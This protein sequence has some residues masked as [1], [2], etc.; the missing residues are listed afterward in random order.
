MSGRSGSC[1]VGRR[2]G[3]DAIEFIS[4]NVPESAAKYPG[5]REILPLQNWRNTQG[6]GSSHMRTILVHM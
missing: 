5:M 6:C 1:R 4:K 2:F 3:S